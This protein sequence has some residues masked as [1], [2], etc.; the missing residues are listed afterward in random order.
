MELQCPLSGGHVP[1]P[2]PHAL[3]ETNLMQHT[4]VLDRSLFSIFQKIFLGYVLKHSES[5][6]NQL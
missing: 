5:H 6:R 4:L 3:N 1:T 2:S